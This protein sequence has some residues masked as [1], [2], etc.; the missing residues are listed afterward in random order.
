MKMQF[1]GMLVY[2]V[3][4]FFYLQGVPTAMILSGSNGEFAVFEDALS[5]FLCESVLKYDVV[6][7]AIT[8]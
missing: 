7:P 5:V 2:S 6:R 3:C 4:F 8:F 1:V